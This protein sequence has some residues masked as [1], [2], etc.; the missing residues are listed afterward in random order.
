[1]AGG[2][3]L[4]RH[5][6]LRGRHLGDDLASV[7]E[8]LLSGSLWDRRGCRLSLDFSFIAGLV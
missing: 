5:E 6:E 8:D 3:V 2:Y 1:M 4:A 7:F